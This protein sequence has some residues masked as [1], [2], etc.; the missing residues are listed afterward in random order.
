MTDSKRSLPLDNKKEQ[1]VHGM[2]GFARRAGKTV[3]GTEQICIAMPRGKIRLV[4]ISSSASDATKKKLSVKSDFYKIP[5]VEVQIDTV[6]LGHM[7]GKESAVAAVAV[8]DERFAEE[9]IKAGKDDFYGSNKGIA[10][11]ERF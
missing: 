3:I 8:A 1:R 9:I 6:S 5:W 10:D 11:F 7:L 4:V 2:L